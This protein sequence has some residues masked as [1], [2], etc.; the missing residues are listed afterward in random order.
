MTYDF[1]YF[2]IKILQSRDWEFSTVNLSID[3]LKVQYEDELKGTDEEIIVRNKC[4]CCKNGDLFTGFRLYYDDRDVKSLIGVFEQ[5][6]PMIPDYLDWLIKT[7]YYEHYCVVFLS[8]PYRKMQFEYDHL[9]SLKVDSN[10]KTMMITIG[11]YEWSVFLEARR[12][13][14]KTLT[15]PFRSL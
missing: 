10:R 4:S 3:H 14:C 1:Y 13:W 11:W 8:S 12:S 5:L 9:I 7:G 15:T 6:R 2:K